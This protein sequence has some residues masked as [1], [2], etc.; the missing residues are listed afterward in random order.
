MSRVEPWHSAYRLARRPGG[1]VYGRL[2][3]PGGEIE[4]GGLWAVQRARARPKG[5]P[6]EAPRRA[7]GLSNT[8]RSL[9]VRA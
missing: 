9:P 3:G 7:P 6:R 4:H 8:N 2:M 1:R 5:N